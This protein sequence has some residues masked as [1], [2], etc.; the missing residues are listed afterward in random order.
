MRGG[1]GDEITPLA[2][3]AARAPG[4]RPAQSHLWLR[5][6]WCAAVSGQLAWSASP[7]TPTPTLAPGKLLL[8]TSDDSWRKVKARPGRLRALVLGDHTWRLAQLCHLHL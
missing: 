6:S 5:P 1:C 3:P 4:L 7:A 8:L 2:G